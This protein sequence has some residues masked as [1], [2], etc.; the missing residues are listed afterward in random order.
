VRGNFP[1]AQDLKRGW[2]MGDSAN[3]CFGQGKIDVTPL[4]MTVM[5][6]AI[7]NGGKVLWP[8]LV[9][10]VEPQGPIMDE[11]EVVSFPPKPP[12]DYLGVHPQTLQIIRDAMLADVEDSVEGTGKAAAIE[13]F[14][15][16]SKTGTAQVKDIEGT[17][18]DYTTW[19][20]SYAPFE[21][22]RYV[23]LVMAEGLGHSGGGTCA[24]IAKKI[25]EA[26]LKQEAKPKPALITEAR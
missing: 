6:A 23:V 11:E 26:I 2:S 16:C 5:V 3:L 14:R 10:R 8:R 21:S 4:Q 9:E 22:P 17:L 20:A 24:P 7:A 12:R 18:V 19:F 25:Y 15:I 13:G 1:S